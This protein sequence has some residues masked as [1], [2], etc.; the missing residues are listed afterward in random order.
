MSMRRWMV[1]L[2]IALMPLRLWAADAMAL[3]GWHGLQGSAA[4]ASAPPCHEAASPAPHGGEDA[5]AAH[6]AVDPESHASCL[7]CDVCHTALG[8]A[9]TD[10]KPGAVPAVHACAGMTHALS[11]ATPEPGYKPPIG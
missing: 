7:L 10:K 9:P 11:S 1:W 3:Q 2:F 6:H 5:H 8:L 4:V